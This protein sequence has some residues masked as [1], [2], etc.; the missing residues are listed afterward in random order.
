VDVVL[1]REPFRAAAEAADE[2]ASRRVGVEVGDEEAPARR[3]YPPQ[4]RVN[5]LEAR[6]VAYREP[7]P[8]GPERAGRERERP[9]V[10]G[11]DRCVAGPGEEHRKDEVDAEGAL[12]KDAPSSR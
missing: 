1:D 10:R 12:A 7:A 4:L 3:E 6:N 2:A 11:R 5:A 8:G 9:D